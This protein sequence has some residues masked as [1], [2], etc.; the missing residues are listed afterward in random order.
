MSYLYNSTGYP[1]YNGNIV[2]SEGC[3]VYDDKGKAYLDF[4]AGVWCLPLGHRHPEIMSA[5][6]EQMEDG[7]ADRDCDHHVHGE[8]CRSTQPDDDGAAPRG[9]HQRREHRLV[10]E[11]A[12][13]DDREDGKDDVELH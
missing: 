13:E 11:L 6:R 9:Q 4:E 3:Y 1:M 12:Q 5:M 2:G 10:R 7:D 8:G